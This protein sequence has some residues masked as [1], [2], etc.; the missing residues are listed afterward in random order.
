MTIEQAAKSMSESDFVL[1]YVKEAYMQE[2]GEFKGISEELK[3][4]SQLVSITA[5]NALD[6]YEEIINQ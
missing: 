6:I 5:N 3:I 1:H 4:N 2:F